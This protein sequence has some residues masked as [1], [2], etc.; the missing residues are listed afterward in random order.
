M[1][2]LKH[3]G[4]AASPEAVHEL[5]SSGSTSS[6]LVVLGG[7]MVGLSR[8][9]RCARASERRPDPKVGVEFELR[10]SERGIDGQF[11]WLD[12]EQAR[13]HNVDGAVAASKEMDEIVRSDRVAEFDPHGRSAASMGQSHGRAH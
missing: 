13:S 1:S 6:P 7:A 11:A 8:D 4:G 3:L 5:M 10:L 9:E 12:L 2:E